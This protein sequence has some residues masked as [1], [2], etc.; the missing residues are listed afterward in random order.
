[1]RACSPL[2][3]FYVDN[4]VTGIENVNE[5]IRLVKKVRKLCAMGRLKL[6]KFE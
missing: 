6:H 4:G 5:A 3:D 1:M 2:T